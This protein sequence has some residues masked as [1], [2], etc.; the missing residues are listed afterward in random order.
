MLTCLEEKLCVDNDTLLDKNVFFTTSDNTLRI[1]YSDPYANMSFTIQ[2]SAYS[3]KDWDCEGNR[4]PTKLCVPSGYDC[5]SEI[6]IC[7][8]AKNSCSGKKIFGE[9]M[10]CKIF[11]DVL[12]VIGIAIAV[13]AGILISKKLFQHRTEYLSKCRNSCEYGSCGLCCYQICECFSQK[14]CKKGP[15]QRDIGVIMTRHR[16]SADTSTTRPY[17]ETSE[18]STTINN[19]VSSVTAE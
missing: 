2:F 9:T 6:R 3:N 5:S 11:G 7:G 15:E 8:A 17:P 13:I 19:G 1:E 16:Q 18:R 4:C 10:S 12:R 14:C